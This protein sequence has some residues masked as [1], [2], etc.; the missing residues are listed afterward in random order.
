MA[1][2]AY[3]E[4]ATFAGALIYGAVRESGKPCFGRMFDYVIKVRQRLHERRRHTLIQ[5]DSHAA[6][7]R[8]TISRA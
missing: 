7:F 6:Q 1:I 5:K 8:A 3:E 2:I 4:I